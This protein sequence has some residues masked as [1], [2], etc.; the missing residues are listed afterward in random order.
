MS[1]HGWIP[2]RSAHIARP[3]NCHG[4]P[5]IAVIHV[6]LFAINY[7]LFI[8]FKKVINWCLLLIP[9]GKNRFF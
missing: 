3:P 4:K 7:S 6:S 1:S 9:K 2:W 8:I 5:D